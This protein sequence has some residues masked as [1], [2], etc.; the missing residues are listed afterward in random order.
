PAFAQ[1]CRRLQ[2]SPRATGP[3]DGA[4][5]TETGK[6]LARVQKLL[7]LADNDNVHEA[8][9][10]MAAANKLLLEHNLQHV[11]R[12]EDAQYQARLVGKA[13]GAFDV[14][15]K[16]V[17]AILSEFFFVECI[18][19]ATYDARRDQSQRQLEIMGS[20][21]NL[22]L[23]HYVHDFLHRECEALWQ[24]SQT[25]LWSSDRSSKREFKAGVLMGFRD[26]LRA[27]RT[28]S[29]ARGLVWLGDP[30]LTAYTRE[31][32]PRLVSTGS[33]GVA[34]SS[35]LA[36]GRAA[37]SQLSVHPGV[38]HPAARGRLLGRS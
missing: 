19:V 10:A 38:S 13:A 5:T 20:E 26:K 7:A 8:E 12:Q 14:S 18:W 2:T 17:A 15:A 31:R 27:E 37:G 11:V 6:I 36:A 9:A 3:R 33:A 4:T 24:R 1:T 35:A 23:A 25:G 34:H 28:V 21:T 32:Y 16:L 30:G 22:E 29:R